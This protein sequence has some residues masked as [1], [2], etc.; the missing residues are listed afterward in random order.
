[1]TALNPLALEPSSVTLFENYAA[2]T[3]REEKL[4]LDELATLIRISTAPTKD[5]AP[6]LKLARFGDQRSDKG[7]LRH[8]A[9][10]VAITGIEADYDKGA[11]GFYK[12]VEIA[13]NAQ[14]RSVLYTS[15]SHKPE[16]AR[17][18]ILCPT[19]AELEPRERARLVSWV[20]GLYAAR[21]EDGPCDVFARESWTL[22]QSYYY[23]RVARSPHYRVEAV[24]GIPIDQ[25]DALE[26][27][28]RGRPGG[29]QKA[30]T[31]DDN[32]EARQDAELIR[33]VVT[34]EHF[35]IELCALAGRYVGR[36]MDQR[37]VAEIL[38]GL[39]LVHPEEARDARWRDRYQSL[40]AIVA[41]AASKFVPE[42]DRRRAIASLTHRMLR[43][44]CSG[45]VIAAVIATEA[46]RVNFP[47]DRALDIARSILREKIGGT[48]VG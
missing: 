5:A 4:T 35:H 24:A 41:S 6:W 11:V 7:S 19:M 27:T 42:A 2:K 30:G 43:G 32:G 28:A 40:D 13:K 17:W 44:G 12:A 21:V 47:E 14:L 10:V 31:T 20:H 36:G 8:D 48:K 9:N 33:C 39:M 46:Q 22:S 37:A 3:K 18:R 1:M 45:P 29:T 16:A 15:A 34:G 26:A 23:G 38:R 25:L